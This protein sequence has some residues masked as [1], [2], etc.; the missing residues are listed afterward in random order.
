MVSIVS[1]NSV[2]EIEWE[3][4]WAISQITKLS[5]EMLYA[6]FKTDMHRRRHNNKQPSA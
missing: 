5:L 3:W 6:E 4:E 2:E 1:P